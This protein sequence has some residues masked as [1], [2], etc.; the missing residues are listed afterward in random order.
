MKPSRELIKAEPELTAIDRASEPAG[1]AH[2]Y[3][4]GVDPNAETEVHLLDYWRAVEDLGFGQIALL[5]P[6]KPL[7][8][9]LRLLDEYAALVAQY[10]G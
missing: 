6:T 2:S 8:E 4:Y 10:R 1:I 7:D 9:S 5:L 3:N